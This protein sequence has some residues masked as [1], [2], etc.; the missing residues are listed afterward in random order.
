[1]HLHT[2]AKYFI[3]LMHAAADDNDKHIDFLFVW[4]LE[5]LNNF[6]IFYSKQ[7]NWNPV[8]LHGSQVHNTWF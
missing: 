5:E 1:M 8:M 4:L 6:Q 2:E 7:W 3:L